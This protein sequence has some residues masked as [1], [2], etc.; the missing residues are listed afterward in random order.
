M[1]VV[2]VRI[3]KF[4][5]RDV[6]LD[7]RCGVNIISKS[8]R[9]KVGLRNPQLAPFVVRMVDQKKAQ[10]LGLIRKLK[11][12]LG[13]YV[14]KTLVTTLN[15][16]HRIEAYSMLLGQSWLKQTKA[17]HNWGDSIITIIFENITIMFSTIKHVNIKSSQKP[18]NLD[19]E[20]DWKEGLFEQK[21]RNYTWV[22]SQSNELKNTLGDHQ[23][24]I[25]ILILLD[26]FMWCHFN[27]MLIMEC[28]A[29]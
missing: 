18:K 6:L 28:C 9:K 26:I 11:I 24:S 14:Y 22:Q 16:E 17:H 5:V 3:G 27:I 8:L 15:M 21:K 25:K 13:G 20:F 4:G 19:N 29:K 7:G 2:Q 10:P 1:L 12:Y 23:N